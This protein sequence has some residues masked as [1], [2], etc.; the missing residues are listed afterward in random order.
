MRIAIL[1]ESTGNPSGFGQQTRILSEGLKNKGYD[2]IVLA[3]SSFPNQPEPP[4]GVSQWNVKFDDLPAIDKALSRAKPDAV[5]VFWT[6]YHLSLYSHLRCVSNV[7]MFFWLPWEASTLKPE[8]T[9]IFDEIPDNHIVSLTQ[10]G[11]D[12]WSPF[13]KTDSIIPHGLDLEVWKYDPEKFTP[14]HRTASRKEWS[15]RLRRTIPDDAIVILNL[16]RNIWHKRWDATYDTLR[17]V[18]EMVGDSRPV[19]L[20]AHTQCQVETDEPFTKGFNL[21]ELEKMYGVEGN[22]LYTGFDWDAGLTTDELVELYQVCDVRISTSGGEGFGIPTIE[23]QALGCL[24]AVTDSTTMPEL[25]GENHISLVRPSTVIVDP[26]E[27]QTALWECPSADRMANKILELDSLS[28][29]DKVVLRESGVHRVKMRY[30]QEIM[31]DLWDKFLQAR[32]DTSE[33]E[34][35]WY[36]YRWGYSRV[37]GEERG[38]YALGDAILRIADSVHRG[39]KVMVVGAF[40]G[41]QVDAFLRLG[42]DTVGVEPDAHAVSIMS[43]QAR[44]CVDNVQFSDDWPSASVAVVTDCVDLI[45]AESDASLEIVLGKLSHYEWIFIRFDPSG[46]WGLPSLDSVK[47]EN[48]LESVGLSRRSDLEESAKTMEAGKYLT[49]QIWQRGSDTS[50]MPVGLL[51]VEDNANDNNTRANLSASRI[52]EIITQ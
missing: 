21:F 12:L 1:S 52:D 20:I 45:A 24:Q 11:K 49:H 37:N 47:V 15:K 18:I 28:A 25:L 16:D 44:L 48:L 34:G 2:V 26:R 9:G 39:G 19:Q 13:I 32:V 7:P 33:S 22:V 4:E 36:K 29:V 10:F 5:I 50:V 8:M 17:R 31:T 46:K 35:Y 14:D 30:S 38:W 6:T 42:L 43:E 3:T 51:K 40:D 27:D 41:K 23:A